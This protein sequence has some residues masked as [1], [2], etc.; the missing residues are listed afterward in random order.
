LLERTIARVAPD[1]LETLARQEDRQFG[2]S[3]EY[4]GSGYGDGRDDFTV[5]QS[6]VRVRQMAEGERHRRGLA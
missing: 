5:V 3:V 4:L 6:F 2:L 1:L